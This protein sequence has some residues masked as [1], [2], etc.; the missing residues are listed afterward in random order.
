M[1]E[2]KDTQKAASRRAEARFE[3]DA[4]I[5]P[6][7]SVSFSL[8]SREPS[9][10]P[11]PPYINWHEAIELLFVLR[12]ELY[13][14]CGEEL[15]HLREGELVAVDPFVLHGTIFPDSH[16][17]YFYI[18]IKPEFYEECGLPY[19]GI[20]HKPRIADPEAA[21]L[22]YHLAEL[23]R[24]KE[25]PLFL[26]RFKATLMLLVAHLYEHYTVPGAAVSDRRGKRMALVVPALEYIHNHLAERLTVAKIAE[27]AHVSESHLLHVFREA[28]GTSVLQYINHLR[29]LY[30]KTLFATTSLS[31]SEVAAACG[32]ES[33][34]DFGKED[35][36]RMGITPSAA[37]KAGKEKA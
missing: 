14:L 33:L 1:S 6:R 12:G 26:P 5:A 36:R 18:K 37:R 19:E 27:V 11:V 3:R 10:T 31:V 8:Q 21:R 9:G 17:E 15:I 25:D 23:S 30:A 32:F 22:F 24:K 35:A 29:F 2:K 28:T 20:S 34:S 4:G 13:V 7:L 16:Q